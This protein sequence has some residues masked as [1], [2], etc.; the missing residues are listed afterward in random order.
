M[1]SLPDQ[2]PIY[3]ITVAQQRGVARESSGNRDEKDLEGK[4][5]V[6]DRPVKRYARGSVAQAGIRKVELREIR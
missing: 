1:L 6:G 3:L 4:E 2:L 5:S